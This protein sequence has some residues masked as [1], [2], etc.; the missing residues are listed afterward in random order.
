MQYR[1]LI[2]KK[3]PVKCICI[4]KSIQNPIVM[5]ILNRVLNMFHFVLNKAKA[6]TF[7]GITLILT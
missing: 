3:I 5:H 7:T 4:T 6:K 2:Q 1:K